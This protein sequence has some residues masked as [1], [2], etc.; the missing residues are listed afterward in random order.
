MVWN[1]PRS[2]PSAMLVVGQ[3]NPLVLTR[4]SA[5]HFHEAFQ[6]VGGNL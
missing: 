3:I 2:A 4:S 5:G 1:L 6:L